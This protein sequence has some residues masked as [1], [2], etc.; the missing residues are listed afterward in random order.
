[1]ERCIDIS[2]IQGIVDW[3]KVYQ[4]GCKY[5][6]I[7]ATQGH[8]V[9]AAT[10]NLFCFTDSRFVSNITKASALGVKCGVY[11]YMTARTIAEANREADYFLSVITP[12]KNKI[13][14]WVALD[15]EDPTY[16]G[17]L[18]SG[19]LT[20]VTKHFLQRI[21][22]AGYF[23]ILYTN[24]NYLKNRFEKNAFK[25][26]DVW[27]AH[28]GVSRPYSVPNMKIWQYGVGRQVGV[29]GNCDLNYIYDEPDKIIELPKYRVGCKYTMKKGDKYSNGVSVPRSLIGKTY[30]IGSVKNDRIL[31]KEI[32]SWVK[33]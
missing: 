3:E 8:G 16:L 9:G 32:Y 29:A 6:M 31:L 24:P 21:K 1:M 5:A 27:L 7:K 20:T 17:K 33:I 12:Y 23:P 11:H 30:T 19:V 13:K 10:K 15:V 26:Y 2:T 28:Y 22:D 25:D 14:L 4:S 18:S